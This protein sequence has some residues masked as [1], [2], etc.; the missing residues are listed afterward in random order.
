MQKTI[1]RY[2]ILCIQKTSIM[3]G[4][5]AVIEGVMMRVP[6]AYATAVRSPS[7]KIEIQHHKYT[8]LVDKLKLSN[9]IILRGFIHLVDSM[10][11]GVGTLDWS[12]Q[13]SEASEKPSNKFADFIMT[14]LSFA[15]AISLFM[16]IPYT[17]TEFLPSYLPVDTNNHFLFNLIAGVSRIFIFLIYLY[18]I[19][20]LNDVKR[21]FQYHG[22]EHKVVYNFESGQSINVKNAK[23]FSTKHPRCGTSFVFILM[24]V[25]ILSYGIVDTLVSIIWQIE[26]LKIL[27]RVAIHLICLPLVAGIGYEVLKFFAKHQKNALFKVLSKPGLWLQNITT[28]EPDN[29]QLEVSIL[30]LE[31]AFDKKMDQFQGKKF[32]ADAI[33]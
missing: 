19:S 12:S 8:S 5:Q 18:A 17:I 27:N 26:N 13:I 6:G 31:A 21:L 22:A 30:A 14:V 23:E 2:L 11:I 32:Q 33:G 9:I 20:H 29:A 25:T 7:G 15:F 4:G 3:V 16:G 10:K 1:L 28:S 24:M